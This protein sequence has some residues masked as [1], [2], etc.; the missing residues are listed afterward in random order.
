M[1][2]AQHLGPTALPADATRPFRKCLEQYVDIGPGWETR[3]AAFFQGRVKGQE[4]RVLVRIPMGPNPANQHARTLR[5]YRIVQCLRSTF[6]AK[7][8]AVAA[9]DDGPVVVYIDE[10]ARP[11]GLLPRSSLSLL[12]LLKI[13]AAFADGLC[14]L[15]KEGLIHGNLNLNNVWIGPEGH[16]LRISDFGLSLYPGVDAPTTLVDFE[17]DPRFIAPEQT[18]RVHQVVDQRTDI[19]TFG[20]ALFWLISGQ[21]P[22][23]GNDLMSILDR[24][25]TAAAS[26]PAELHGRIPTPVMNLA[27]KCLEKSSDDRYNSASG[28]RT[29]LIECLSQLESGGAIHDF[30]LGRYDPRAAFRMPIRLYGREVDTNALRRFVQNQ[31]SRRAIMLVTGNPGVGKTAFLNQIADIAAKQN[32][33]FIAGKFDQYRRNVPYFSIA[34]AFQ[35]L[36]HQMLAQSKP[37][38]D[39]YRAQILTA[40]EGAAG[41]I[42]DVIPEIELIIGKQP[43]VADLPPLE[44]R[45]RFNRIF[46]NAISALAA[47]QQ[48]ICLFMD[49]LQWADSASLELLQCLLSDVETRCLIFVAAYRE[50]ETSQQLEA[51]LERLEQSGVECQRMIL[52]ELKLADVQQLVGDTIGRPAQEVLPLAELLHSRTQGNPLYLSQLLH[53]LYD[54]NLLNFDYPAGRWYWDLERIRAEALTNDVLDLLR[55]RISALPA[56]TKYIL[57]VAACLGSPFDA[58]RLTRAAAKADVVPALMRCIE[59][60]LLIAV[61]QIADDTPA[62]AARYRD[63]QFR[64]LHD[65]IQQAAFDLIPDADRKS[66]RLQIGRRL[67]VHLTAEQKTVPQIDVLNNF[68]YAWDVI[69]SPAEKQEVSRLN[70]IAGSKARQTL[71]YKE[72][73]GFLSTGMRLLGSE[74]WKETHELAF[75]L[76]ANALECEYLSGGFAR[77]EQLF[78]LLLDKAATKL[79]KAKVYLTKILLDTSE[80]RYENAIQVGI[81]ALRL[82]GIRYRR[83]PG[84][85]HLGSELIIARARTRGRR[86]SALLTAATMTDAEKIAALKILVALFPTAY[87]LSPDLLMFSSLKVVNYSLRYGISH[88]SAGGFVLYGLVMAAVLGKVQRGYEFGRLALELAERGQDRAVLCKVLII[89]ALFIKYWRDPLDE[90]FPLIERARI[91]ALQSGDHQYA[92]YAIIGQL[93][94]DFSRG[95]DLAAVR[96]YCDRY[97]AFV[98]Q[99][100]DA[101]PIESLLMWQSSVLALTGHTHAAHSLTSA[102]YDEHAAEERYLRTHNLTLLCYQYTL[103]SQLCYLFGR[104]TEARA[105]SDRGAAFI[106]SAPGQI[107][108]VDYYLYRGLAATATRIATTSAGPRLRHIARKCLSKLNGFAKNSPQNFSPHAK[109]LEADLAFAVGDRAR[110]MKLFNE[111]VD[112]AEQQ[113]FQ[114]LVALANERAALCALADGQRRAAAAHLIWARSAYARWGASAKVA[115]LDKEYQDVFKLAAADEQRP[116]ARPPPSDRRGDESFDVIAAMA[117]LQ[118]TA[119]KKDKGRGL[120]ELLMRIRAQTAAETAYLLVPSGDGYRVEAA[121][122]ATGVESPAEASE[123]GNRYSPAVVNYVVHTGTDLII[124]NAHLDARFARCDYLVSCQPKSVMCAAIIKQSELLGVIYLEHRRLVGA[125]DQNKLQWLRILQSEVALALHAH[126]LGRYRDYIHRFTPRLAAK[127]IDADPDNPDLAAREMDVSILF[128]DL[129]GYTRLYEL[130]GHQE[131]DQFVNRAFSEFIAEIDRCHGAVLDFRG[132]ELFVLFQGGEHGGHAV[133][134]VTAAL[135]IR[136]AAEQLN[137]ARASGQPAITANMGINSGAAVVG[138]QPVEMIAGARWRYAATGMT[139]NVAARVRELARNGDILISAAT[140]A[141]LGG[142]FECQDI[143]AHAL[144]NVSTPIKILRL[145]GGR[146]EALH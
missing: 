113:K 143:G 29:D 137:Q 140:A 27:L 14:D 65:R 130:M 21:V 122:A 89:F 1:I 30:A 33:R 116:I 127:E 97:E 45:N 142:T 50:A 54:R 41:L 126:K 83:H 74:A 132:D 5:D 20:V 66:F 112:L 141:R 26:F 111:V 121:A 39:A 67:L 145:I 17:R 99:S 42:I 49:D 51:M 52:K 110:A 78:A 77:A 69:R 15:H 87:F 81:Q 96:A 46:R 31:K 100:K 125:F 16:G 94:L 47:A 79:A 98:R 12:K 101:F 6:V 61:N 24:Q 92:N 93:S 123:S 37:E 86:A 80:E 134:A 82:F 118:D 25:L 85:L 59:R 13:A 72:A 70:L 34:Q 128:V 106:A 105:M 28:L 18:G 53:F 108:V 35:P 32:W 4:Q 139:V 62:I 102:S 58:D 64:F 107:S 115:T 120:A 138:L 57:S 3:E 135:A 144:K 60:D 44:S 124:D 76:H 136:Q 84:M 22:F 88:L 131:A 56:Q 117:T 40:C 2:D 133:N 91:L 43:P 36:I 55:M 129:A 19:Y 8:F 10:G 11:L 104:H 114:H 119:V 75:E 73:L 7:V 48:A 9:T 38:I 109:L 103:R 146:A 71:A 68:N 95:L 63:N 23:A 90:S